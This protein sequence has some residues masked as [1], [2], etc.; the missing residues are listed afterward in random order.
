MTVFSGDLFSLAYSLG[1]ITVVPT[2]FFPFF[3]FFGLYRADCIRGGR[4]TL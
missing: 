1:Y 4:H 3:S 2:L